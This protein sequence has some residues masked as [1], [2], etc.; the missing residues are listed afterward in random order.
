VQKN[1]NQSIFGEDVDKSLR[2]TFFGHPVETKMISL[3]GLY[4]N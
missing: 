2:L 1:E 4:E 3:K